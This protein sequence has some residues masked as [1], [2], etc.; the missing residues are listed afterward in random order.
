M[1]DENRNGVVELD[2]GDGTHRFRLGFGELEELQE[3]TGLGPFVLF[4][5][6][7]GGEWRLADV[8][9]TLRVGLI[10]GGMKPLDALGLVRRYV[11]ERQDWITH[12]GRAQAIVFAAIAGAPEEV[13]GKGAAPEAMTEASSLPTDAS[14]SADGTAPLAPSA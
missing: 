3:K 7:L 14:P 2:F 8:R 13:P 12:A 10:G 5:R 9:E 11:D 1:A 4:Q 6:L